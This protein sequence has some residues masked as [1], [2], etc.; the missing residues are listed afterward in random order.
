[1]GYFLLMV[2]KNHVSLFTH[3]NTLL[4]NMWSAFGRGILR[5]RG[6][7][8][9]SILI[10]TIA[11]GYVATKIELSYSYARVLPEDDSSYIDY[12][13]FTK[14]YGEDGNVLVLGFADKNIFELKKFAGWYALTEKIKAISGIKDVMSVTRLYKLVRNDSL[15]QFDLVPIIKQKP[16]SQIEV[17]SLKQ[18]ILNLPF[19][20][21]LALNKTQDATLMAIT[22][23]KKDLDSKNRL[24]IVADIEKYA[25]EFAKSNN[26]EVHY[27]GMPYIRTNYMRKVG[28]EMKVF[29]VLAILVTAIILW[30]LFRSFLAVGISLF[31]CLVGVVISLATIVLMG[32][33]ITVLS[34]LIPP[35][36][37]VIGVPNC[38]F[39]INKYQ[40]ELL[41]HGNKIKALARTIEKVAM[42]NL[43]ANIT[44]AIGFAVFYFTDS[45]L[46]V[47]FG[48]VASVNVL[49]T[50]LIAHILLPVIYSYVPTPKAKHTKHLKGKFIHRSLEL[51]D[52]LVHNHRKK[53][54]FT[55]T[56]LTLLSFYGMTKMKL[57]GHVV[58]DLPQRD[59]IY[60]H[61]KFF[62]SNFSG[63]LPFEINVDTKKRNGV[64]ADNAR[65]LY[66]IKSMQKLMEQYP[67]FS[68]PISAVEVLKFAYQAYKDGEKKFYILPGSME[69]KNLSDYTKSVKGKED[70][71]SSFIDTAKQFTRVSFQMADIGSDKMKT[72]VSDIKPRIDSIFNYNKDAAAWVADSSKYNVMLTGH[73]LVFLKSNDY[74]YHHLFVSLLIAI[75]LILLI[76]MILFRSIAIIV[77]SKLPCLIPLA[78]TAGIM[79][80]LNIHFKP[81]TIL[82][83]SIA[84]G[85]AS[86]G[87]I[88]ILTEYRNQL[89][90]SKG[91]S[92][93]TAISRT[94]RELGLSM[95]YTNIILFFGFIIFAASSFGG[96]VALG[97]LISITLLVS[98]ITNL[99]LLPCI[100]LSLEKWN[101]NKVLMQDSLIEIIDEEEDIDLEKLEVQKITEIEN[102]N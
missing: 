26:I 33:K 19:Y 95:I 48:L 57:V 30:L 68:R 98:L 35:L 78:M 102:T 96:T 43:L 31:V 76:G 90:K 44:T 38:I 34:G 29:M 55:I 11:A 67:E 10:L 13:K 65:T 46:L 93:A 28:A 59:P 16:L 47:E 24:S 37:M 18:E 7:V 23:E 51:V 85:I 41:R 39:I 66:K 77:L 94:I 80:F 101:Q 81:S 56:V 22:F 71:L 6:T 53:I 20:N 58:D 25:E 100:L 88:Y 3:K 5:Y 50:Y 84:F 89:R 61:L 17:D 8:F 73:S 2:A 1:M 83:F 12:Q 27:S 15:T 54:Y 49:I 60:T 42:S 99:V 9:I 69:L 86:D 4:T 32:Y 45:T 62:E 70:R 74:L 36:I 14:L 40:E 52:Y 82:I 92:Q 21:G 79:G 72:L 91:Q 87:T 64:F 63:V 97:V 75:V